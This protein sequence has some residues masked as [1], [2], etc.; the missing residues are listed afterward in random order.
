MNIAILDDDFHQIN[1]ISNI[2]RSEGHIC[3]AFQRDEDVLM[4]L[5]S[6]NFDLLIL[7]GASALDVL[8]EIRE[9]LPQAIPILF[10]VDNSDEE[11][12]VEGL[13]AGADSCMI[14]PIR[15]NELSARVQALVRRAYPM[16]ANKKIEFSDYLFDMSTHQLTRA[17]K[18][19]DIS[20]KEFDLALLF[21]RNLDCPLTRTYI[22]ETVWSNCIP[23]SYQTLYT[24]IA[25]IRDKLQLQVENGYRLYSIYRY[26]YQLQRLNTSKQCAAVAT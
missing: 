2:L 12:I 8:K 25:N 1:L 13:T 23:V 17:S 3:A 22:L 9:Q 19:I 14:K 16:N 26:G 5:S 18:P 20:P 15:G 7:G 4:R 11:G 10:V 6:G 24:H 21:F